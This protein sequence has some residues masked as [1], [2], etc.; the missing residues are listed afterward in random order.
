MIQNIAMVFDELQRNFLGLNNEGTKWTTVNIIY[1]L[2]QL[3][4]MFP[5]LEKYRKY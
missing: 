2:K 5:F 3:T 4:Q 1:L